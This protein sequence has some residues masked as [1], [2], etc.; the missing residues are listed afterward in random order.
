[1][2]IDSASIKR[3]KSITFKIIGLN[4]KFFD[5]LIAKTS[6]NEALTIGNC[7]FNTI[8]EDI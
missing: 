5:T 7:L 1:M 3:L 4:G 6:G 8:T 2:E